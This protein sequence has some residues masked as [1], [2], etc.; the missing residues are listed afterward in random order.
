M[1]RIH[2]ID[3]VGDGRSGDLIDLPSP[4]H[5][6]HV[7]GTA[8]LFDIRDPSFPQNA[9]DEAVSLLHRIEDTFSIFIRDSEISR[10]AR[11]DL[12]IDDAT[13]TVR[14]VL[15]ACESLRS[16]TAAAFDHRPDGGLDPSGYVK[17]WAVEAAAGILTEAGVDTF[18]VSA[19]G[20]I[21]ARGAPSGADAWNVGIRDPLDRDATLGTVALRNHAIA[22][23]GR[24]ERGA[25]IWGMDDRD[26]ELASVSIVGPDLGI[27]D[28][29]ATAV[30]AAGLESIAWLS[31]FPEYHLI[32]VTSGRRILRSPKAPFSA[33]E[34]TT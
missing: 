14:D 25:H 23:S 33:F 13:A 16:D 5:V 32:A 9:L 17:G 3:P 18:L 26:G 7:M 30:F 8:V 29:L 6:E 15:A 12:P 24:Y 10:I 21:V 27:A 31:N 20:D 34:P 11:G 22:T 4:T 2:G 19:G 28:A 1:G